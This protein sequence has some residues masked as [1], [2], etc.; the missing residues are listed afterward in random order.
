MKQIILEGFDKVGKSTLA[1]ELSKLLNFKVIHFPLKGDP[2]N[3]K[4]SSRD[5]FILTMINEMKEYYNHNNV[6][7]DR[8]CISTIIYQKVTREEL[9][10]YKLLRL[11]RED[12]LYV[13]VEDLRL[14]SFNY[15]TKFEIIMKGGDIKP[16]HYLIVN[17]KDNPN[18]A[19]RRI[20]D[21]LLK[22]EEEETITEEE[23]KGKI[24]VF[25]FFER[26]FKKD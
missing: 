17:F 16:T 26:M 1:N 6:I 19:I 22:I 7:F 18:L 11:L 4:A 5:E 12:A 23:N 24:D 9:Y 2:K 14:E 20:I 15:C 13:C 8:W 10:Y 25:N 21:Q 3:Y